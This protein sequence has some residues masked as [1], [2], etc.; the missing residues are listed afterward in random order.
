[1]ALFFR[2]LLENLLFFMNGLTIQSNI[3]IQIFLSVL[4][5]I[6]L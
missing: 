5:K 6:V 4:F 1:M 3:R 2:V